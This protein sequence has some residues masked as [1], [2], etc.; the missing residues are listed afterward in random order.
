MPT[1]PK[2]GIA[3][4][5][6]KARFWYVESRTRPAMKHRKHNVEQKGNIMKQIQKI[7]SGVVAAVMLLSLGGCAGMSAQGF[8]CVPLGL[9][10]PGGSNAGAPADCG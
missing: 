8:G 5:K 4:R 10:T 3:A 6:T 2:P 7:S 1:P 9:G